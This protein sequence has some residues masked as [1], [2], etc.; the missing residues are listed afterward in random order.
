MDYRYRASQDELKRVYEHAK[1]RMD[2]HP[3]FAEKHKK[4]INELPYYISEKDALQAAIKLWEKDP[5][6]WLICAKV[7]KVDG[8]YRIG[9]F[10]L[11][12]NDGK[13]KLSADYIGM[14]LMYDD[15]RLY[16]I[17]HSGVPIDDVIAYY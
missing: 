9:K 2:A 3:E 4:V 11:V 8:I 14:I 5:W 13:I 10:W 12:T 15:T 1:A 16:N 17:I 6:L 7:E